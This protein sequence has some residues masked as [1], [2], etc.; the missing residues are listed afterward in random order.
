MRLFNSIQSVAIFAALP[1]VISWL[2][3][4]EFR[5]AGA[6]WWVAV[7]AYFI[8]FVAMTACVYSNDELWDK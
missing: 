8:G 4:A 6:G 3:D 2:T 1:F 5:G 7:V